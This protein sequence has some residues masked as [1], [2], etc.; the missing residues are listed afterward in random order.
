M[1]AKAEIFN[2]SPVGGG[3]KV[4][5]GTAVLFALLAVF[6]LVVLPFFVFGKIVPPNYIGVRQ[7]Y[8]SIFGLL[9]KGYS[10]D[11][12]EPGL[13]WKIP[14]VTTVIL[15]PKDFQF[16]HLN[17]EQIAGDLDLP[18]LDVPTTDGSKVKTDV[19]LIV[20]LFES[21]A[22]GAGL[23]ISTE[24]EH[25]GS[26]GNV[27]VPLSKVKDRA[28]GGPKDL[29][30]SFS[31]DPQ[32]QLLTLSR[33]AEN[34]LKQNLS[35]LSTTDYYNPEL[36]EKAAYA[37]NEAING[38]VNRSGIELW[39]TLIRRYGYAEKNIDDQ[40]FAKNLQDQTERLNAAASRLAAAK[41]DTEQSRALWDAKIRDLQVESQAK[42]AVLESEGQLYQSK[43]EA[44]GNLLVTQAKAEVD[45][46]KANVLSQVAGAEVFVARE[47]AP[48]LQ[49]L[50]GGI[51]SNIDPYDINQW[52]NRLTSKE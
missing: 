8:Y 4:K 20:R 31:A 6:A 35:N 18:S 29:V 19:T 12:L 14:G 5:I 32:R 43:K 30:T 17:N 46:A 36:R 48:L 52:V 49:T 34:E 39:A 33:T 50:S 44:E 15:L 26:A 24:A 13:Q 45:G 28:H 3:S 22:A 42:V 25:T 41:A 21:S 10:N 23:P 7:N 51:V 38:I 37:S 11:G 47:M 40:I 9:E 1:N 27:N 16:V 2:S